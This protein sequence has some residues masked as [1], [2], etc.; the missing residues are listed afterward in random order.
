MSFVL[1]SDLWRDWLGL[2]MGAA[3]ASPATVRILPIPVLYRLPVAAVIVVWGARTD[4][5][6]TVPIAS[7]IALP[8]VFFGSLALLVACVPLLIVG[9][10]EA[11]GPPA[12]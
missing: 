8:T 3:D 12:G 9:R 4:R 5:R 7:L 2:L 6:W 11:V 10:G 1:A